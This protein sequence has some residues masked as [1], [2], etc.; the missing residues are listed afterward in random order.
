M[1]LEQV[2]GWMQDLPGDLWLD[3]ACGEGH[4]GELAGGRAGLL[5]LDIDPQRLAWARRRPYRL[6]LRGTLDAMPFADNSLD[7]IV[8]V[9]T[10][11]HVSRLDLV[12]K[13]CARCLRG[14]GYMVVTVPSVTLRSW[15]QMR[16][17][18][19]PVYC[20]EREHLRE[21]SS[22]PIRWFPNMFETWEQFER[23]FDVQG[24][25]I[26]RTG[27]IGFLFPMWTGRLAWVE[28]GMN[29]L[30]RE[31]CN[32]WLGQLPLVSRFPYYRLYLL[33]RRGGA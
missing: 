5:G 25:D 12:L 4:L 1:L 21:L 26:V 7:G 3:G 15:W 27:G 22:V 20:S 30:Y 8:S 23:R 16:R 10:L 28:R 13:E 17:T 19:R 24:F 2:S 11:E 31:S 18:G 9:E 14:G 33:R 32:R 29:L 6:L